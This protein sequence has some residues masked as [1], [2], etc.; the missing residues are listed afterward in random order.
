MVVYKFKNPKCKPCEFQE[1]MKLA[2]DGEMIA[3]SEKCSDCDFVKA[4]FT[5][6]QN[7][8]TANNR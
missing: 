1:I 6:E 5:W 4:N 8:D 2:K 7:N 3:V